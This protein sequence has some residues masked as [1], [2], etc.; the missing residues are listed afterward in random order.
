[1]SKLEPWKET[2]L[3]KAEWEDAMSLGNYMGLAYERIL[4]NMKKTLQKKQ[5]NHISVKNKSLYAIRYY[6]KIKRC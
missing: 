1:M 5:R 2:N 4:H 6:N 3:T